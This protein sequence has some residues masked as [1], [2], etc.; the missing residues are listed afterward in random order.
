MYTSATLTYSY[1]QFTHLR[2]NGSGGLETVTDAGGGINSIPQTASVNLPA[3]LAIHG[4]ATA[5]SLDL[6]VSTSAAFTDHGAGQ[7][8]TYA[9][10]PIFTLATV[11]PTGQAPV[12]IRGVDGLVTSVS[13]GGNSLSVMIDYGF[14]NAVY[15]DGSTFTVATN[16]STIYQGIGSF[17][18]LAA[19]MIANLD[20]ALQ[21]D[22]TLLATRIEVDDPS[23]TNVLTGPVG[24][25]LGA[26]GSIVELGRINEEFNQN[27]VPGS[28][29]MNYSFDG[30]TAFKISGETAVPANL[31]FPAMFDSS[32]MMAGQNVAVAS[33]VLVISGSTLTKATTIT[34]KPQTINGTITGVSSSGGFTVYSVSLAA[35]GL[36]PALAM[37]AGQSTALQNASAIEIYVDSDTQMLNSNTI[38]VGNVLRFNGLIFN[39]SGTARMVCQQ[40]NDGVAE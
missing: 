16:G 25:A 1:A 8:D 21:S 39:D 14:N 15:P 5:V 31:P 30:S 38:A 34:L 17:S 27:D 19:G 23:A 36:F 6:Q 40:I 9:L 20:V 2:R 4:S 13:S 22:G 10:T 12:P 37:Q 7:S 11:A 3:A 26:Q 24:T 29:F 32:N 28:N 33:L 35:Y 18:A